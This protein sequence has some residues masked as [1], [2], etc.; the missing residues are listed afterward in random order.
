MLKA[1]IAEA[2]RS[3]TQGGG[4]V[5]CCSCDGYLSA[6]LLLLPPPMAPT[7]P[8]SA[9]HSHHDA[10]LVAAATAS[11]CRASHTDTDMHQELRT[12]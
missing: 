12:R 7:A 11:S 8:L 5:H 1:V 4:G 2:L 10:A 9:W 6:P 3:S